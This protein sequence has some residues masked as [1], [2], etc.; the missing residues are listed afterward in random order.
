LGEAGGHRRLLHGR[1]RRS[2]F[3]GPQHPRE[4]DDHA[5][6]HGLLPTSGTAV[7]GRRYRSSRCP[8]G[9]GS[10]TSRIPYLPRHAGARA[11]GFIA[12]IRFSGGKTRQVEGPG[13]LFSVRRSANPST[14]PRGTD[15]GLL[16]PI[17]SSRPRVLIMD[18]PPT[19]RPQSKHE[20]REM[21]R[22]CQEEP[23]CLYPQPGR[24]GGGSQG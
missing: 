18:R 5:D 21:I 2:R 14:P 12:E 16:R 8:P 22:R 1:A 17:H 13:A 20:V 15:S 6:D 7:W 19:A 24:S 10:G 11:F 23:S 9:S 3:P 4:V